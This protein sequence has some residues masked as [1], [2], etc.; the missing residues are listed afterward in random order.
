MSKMANKTDAR[1]RLH[2]RVIRNVRPTRE[3][4]WI[5]QIPAFLVFGLDLDRH[6]CRESLV[7]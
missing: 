7:F 1:D 5:E 6:S 4:Y 2:P 3:G